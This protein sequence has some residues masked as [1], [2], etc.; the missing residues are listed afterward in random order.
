[1]T[2]VE[3]IPNLD[4]TGGALLTR[5]L[6]RKAALYEELHAVDYAIYQEL[7]NQQL[8]QLGALAAL[9]DGRLVE[10]ERGS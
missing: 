8:S 7:A 9:F 4:N 2:I 10:L 6:D 5:L 3:H 1:M